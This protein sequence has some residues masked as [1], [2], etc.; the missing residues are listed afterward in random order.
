MYPKGQGNSPLQALEEIWLLT[1]K[2]FT[3]KCLKVVSKSLSGDSF[4][5]ATLP[6]KSALAKSFGRSFKKLQLKA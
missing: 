4:V 6:E 1:A 3:A 5:A 2:I